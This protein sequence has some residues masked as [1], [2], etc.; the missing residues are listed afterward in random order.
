MRDALVLLLQRAF[1]AALAVPVTW[2]YTRMWSTAFTYSAP[3]V[4][5]LLARP[6]LE[7]A[8]RTPRALRHAALQGVA[9]RHYA[10][11][12]RSVDVHEDER[13]VRWLSISDVRRCVPGLPDAAVLRRLNPSAC[14][15]TGPRTREGRI[16]ADALAATL[17]K[18][19]DARTG[20]FLKWLERDVARPA[21]HRRAL[22]QGT[23]SVE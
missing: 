23:R 7:L 2:L 21:R 4:A 1:F 15:D 17:G 9:G 5:G 19:T 12:G 20:H 8:G 18:T 10:Y 6:V 22:A 11:R 14:A 3:I 16:T 13:H